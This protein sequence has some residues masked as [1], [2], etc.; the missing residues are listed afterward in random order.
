MPSVTVTPLNGGQLVTRATSSVAGISNY[1]KKLNWIRVLEQEHRRHG[2]DLFVPLPSADDFA[3]QPY[4]AA[5]DDTINLVYL[6]RRANGSSAVIAGTPSRH[7]K[8]S[9]DLGDYI[10][11]YLG[12]PYVLGDSNGPYFEVPT[13]W[14]LIG[15]GFSTDGHRWESSTVSGTTIFNNG[16]DLPTAYRIDWSSEA[17]LYELREQGILT[18][19]TITEHQ[20]ML[21]AADITELA[22]DADLD[23]LLGLVNSSPITVTQDGRRVSGTTSATMTG[24]VTGVITANA[25]FFENTGGPFGTGDVGRIVVFADGQR[26]SVTGYTSATQVSVAPIDAATITAQVLGATFYVSDL[27]NFTLSTRSAY[28]VIAS[29]PLFDASF[30]GRRI[31]WASGESRTVM[32]YIS[33]THV[34]VDRDTPIA[35]APILY[36][37]PDTYAALTNNGDGT[38]SV[39]STNL[40]TSPDRRQ[41]RVLWSLP[42]GP[43]RFAAAIPVTATAGSPILTTTRSIRSI[44]VGQAVAVANAGTN[45]G[46]LIVDANNNPITVTDIGPGYIRLSYAAQ[47]STTEGEIQLTD[48]VGSLIGYADL[49]DDG[50]GIL[51][52]L[53]LQD[54]LVIYKDTSFFL[55]RFTGLVAQPFVF[56]LVP[57]AHGQTLHY[58]F[59]LANLNGRAHIYAGRNS[60]YTFDLTT[61]L[62]QLMQKADLVQDLFYDYA[63]FANTNAIFTA[64]NQV[65]QELYFV[66]PQNTGDPVLAYDY[67][68]DTFSTSD[69]QFTAG[70]MVKSPADNTASETED[71]FVMGN[72]AGTVLIYGS[73]TGPVPLWDN[74]KEIYYRRSA[75]P[76]SPLKT[77]AYDSVL[78]SGQSDFGDEMNEKRMTRYVAQFASQQGASPTFTVKFYTA[79]NQSESPVLKAQKTVTDADSHGLVP[80]HLLFHNM[81]EE[82]TIS[83]YDNPTRLHSR[84]FEV[85]GNADKSNTRR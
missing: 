59:T 58:R 45:G 75:R 53:T 31:G 82:L 48:S 10:E 50:S 7:W 47:T 21:M 5:A 55:G 33:T 34:K 6:S 37:N 73:T 2:Y 60:F 16:V 27:P 19:G 46:L 17:P 1:T 71:W 64:D 67:R 29:A 40:G 81:Q 66:C 8:F 65:T 63:S 77:G 26:V 62:P 32:Q 41:T 24:G 13:R 30:V 23:L 80:V 15:D 49:D 9:L 76:Y 84:I 36:E 57:A 11:D 38:Y 20:S 51:K 43:T 35:A 52:M 44:T 79:K 12:Q 4:P 25:A 14:Q 85:I 54:Q 68:Y 28:S 69:M 70:A 74:G 3:D 78:R 22:T 42:G 61:R 56:E 72:S 39:G 18:V 83:G